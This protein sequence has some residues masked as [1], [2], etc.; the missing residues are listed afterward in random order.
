MVI[1]PNLQWGVPRITTTRARGG[2]EERYSY[3][4]FSLTGE[5]CLD[6]A[7]MLPACLQGLTSVLNEQAARSTWLTEKLVI[8]TPNQV[9]HPLYLEV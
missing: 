6:P 8:L 1:T 3:T 4:S 7:N 2:G 9:P 5:N